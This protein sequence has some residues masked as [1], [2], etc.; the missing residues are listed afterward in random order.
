M[1]T[2]D[3]RRAEATCGVDRRNREEHRTVWSDQIRS[4]RPDQIRSDTSAAAAAGEK[5]RRRPR[6]TRSCDEGREDNIISARLLA[7]LSAYLHNHHHNLLYLLKNSREVKRSVLLRFLVYQNTVLF[8]AFH[9][10][11]SVKGVTSQFVSIIL[12]FKP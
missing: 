11:L 1:Q 9:L 4:D 7:R 5:R 10:R 8:S 3:V 6:E 2:P 12:W